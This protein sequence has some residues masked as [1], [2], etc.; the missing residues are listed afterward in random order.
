MKI[1]D[2]FSYANYDAINVD[3]ISDIFCNYFK[4]IGVQITF[5]DKYNPNQFKILGIDCGDMRVGY[6]ISKNILKEECKLL[7]H[8][9]K[10]FR[11][12]KLCYRDRDGK[13][14]VV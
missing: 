8:E 11:E 14:N 2:Y 10:G 13:L 5:I 4:A 9:H 12:G 7:F 6:V 3:N 1:Y